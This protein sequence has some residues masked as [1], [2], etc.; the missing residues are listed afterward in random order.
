MDV[1]DFGQG[2]DLQS[3]I[4]VMNELSDAKQSPS[5]QLLQTLTSL[6]PEADAAQLNVEISGATTPLGCITC[7]HEVIQR[8]VEAVRTI[9]AGVRVAPDDLIP[10]L[11]WVVVKSKLQDIE[12]LLEY[13][14]TYRLGG[15]LAPEL[16]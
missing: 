10:L 1:C 4:D 7:I 12:S 13:V 14:K 15:N 5:T 2:D 11:A 3:A 9:D 8:I 6:I 16:E